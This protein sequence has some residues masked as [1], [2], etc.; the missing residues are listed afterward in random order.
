MSRRETV[1]VALLGAFGVGSYGNDETLEAAVAGVRGAADR[2]RVDVMLSCVCSDEGVVTARSGMPTLSL[3]GTR[4]WGKSSRLAPIR[5][6]GLAPRTIDRFVRAVRE[7]RRVDV[8]CIAGTGTL[9]DQHVRPTQLPLDVAIWSVAARLARTDLVFASV[10]AGPIDHWASKLLYR[11]AARCARTISYRDQRS[12]EYMRGIGRNVDADTVVPDLVF[13]R[14]EPVPDAVA[15]A[16]LRPCVALGVLQLGHWPTDWERDRYLSRLVDVARGVWDAGFDVSLIGGDAIDRSAVTELATRLG[17]G[18]GDESGRLHTPHIRSFDDVLAAVA[19]C[20][21]TVSSRYH[22]LVAA[23]LVGRP[24]V[25]LE[26][27][28]KNTALMEDFGLGDFCHHIADFAP[29]RVV[30]HVQ[31]L[32][33]DSSFAARSRCTAAE[34][35]R[36]V[37]AQWDGL[38]R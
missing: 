34:M 9:D 1:R 12:K 28:F 11:T 26:Y 2:S 20:A 30:D 8:L 18:A 22:N 15:D 27:G 36:A 13:G 10:G 21:V 37:D 16:P 33:S 35:R 7:L 24:V 6:L 3:T 29:S 31:Q 38:V 32:A 4:D 25:S 17:D 23:F 19:P 14:R 5:L